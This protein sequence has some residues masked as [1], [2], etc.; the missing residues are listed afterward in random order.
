MIL[1]IHAD[2]FSDILSKRLKGENDII[3]KY[4]LDKFKNGGING[5]IFVFW[6]DPILIL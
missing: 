6:Q 1:D 4:H 3:R 5:G 2:I